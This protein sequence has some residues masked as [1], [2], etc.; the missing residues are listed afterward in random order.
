MTDA[1]HAETGDDPGANTAAVPAGDVPPPAA[2][3]PAV[4]APAVLAGVKPAGVRSGRWG[5]W[6]AW[7]RCSG[8]SVAVEAT[9]IAPLLIMLMVFV[10]VVVHRGVDAR[11]RLDDA[12]HQAARAAS[13]ER[14][15]TAAEQ[16][17]RSMA[18]ETM[19]TGGLRC[20]PLTVATTTAGLRAGGVVSVTVSCTVDLSDAVLLGVPGRVRLAA[21]ASE[22]VD[23]FRSVAEAEG[24]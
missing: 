3:A 8:G 20:V 7:W 4:L 5:R 17:A 22:P 11:L 18:T 12:A 1:P 24:K 2:T 13:I 23:T 6:R 10:A 15:G 9:L 21:T 14:T 19:S 16:A